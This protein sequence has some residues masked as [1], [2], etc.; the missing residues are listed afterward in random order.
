MVSADYENPKLYS[1]KTMSTLNQLQLKQSCEKEA[2]QVRF[3]YKHFW[4]FIRIK[5]A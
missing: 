2:F 1:N 3:D 4:D 5:V